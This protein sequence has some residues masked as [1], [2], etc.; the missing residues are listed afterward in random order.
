MGAVGR[1]PAAR[2]RGD[3]GRDMKN[4]APVGFECYL[5]AAVVAIALWSIVF[6]A[7]SIEEWLMGPMA[8]KLWF[9]LVGATTYGAGRYLRYRVQQRRRQ[10][11]RAGQKH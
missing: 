3:D 2:N 4:W 5:I 6:A 1:V 9:G 8:V 7:V 11:G 10:V